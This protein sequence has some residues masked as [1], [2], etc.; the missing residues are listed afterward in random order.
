M[1]AQY[2]LGWC[3]DRGDGVTKDD[4]EAFKWFR[5]A[6]E[7]GDAPAQNHIGVCY[8]NGRGVTKDFVEAYKW[9]NL[10]SVRG[11]ENAKKNLIIVEQ[12]M[13]KEQIA[14][15]Q[16]ISREFKEKIELPPGLPDVQHSATAKP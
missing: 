6:A 4:V 15:A 11:H 13:T 9:F 1:A 2:N 5:R 10:A 8:D 7:Q 16:R 14:E 3:Y 12:R